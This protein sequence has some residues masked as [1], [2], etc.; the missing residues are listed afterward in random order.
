MFHPTAIVTAMG[1]ET[2][3]SGS[4]VVAGTKKTTVPAWKCR[5]PAIGVM[6]EASS[7]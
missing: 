5:I 3:A 1:T 6:A 7:T 2:R 4:K